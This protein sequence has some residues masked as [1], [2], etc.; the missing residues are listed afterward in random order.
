MV[1]LVQTSIQQ[2]ISQLRERFCVVV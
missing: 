2:C 1:K